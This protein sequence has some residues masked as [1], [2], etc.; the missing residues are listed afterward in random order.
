MDSGTKPLA[1][2]PGGIPA[3]ERA[4]HF[5]LARQL[6]GSSAVERQAWR[7]GYAFRFGPDAFPSVARF[8]ENERKCCPFLDFEV[9]VESAGPVWLRMSGPDGTR[10][11]LDAELG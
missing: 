11:F 10:A 3:E 6:F 2:S 5:A 4:A 8:V 1:C 7:E 9:A